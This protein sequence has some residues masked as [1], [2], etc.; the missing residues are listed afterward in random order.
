MLIPDPS[1]IEICL[2]LQVENHQPVDLFFS[3]SHL[4][5]QTYNLL[6]SLAYGGVAIIAVVLSGH[7]IG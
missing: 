3:E 5:I 2:V 7:Q 6:I 1:L 4:F